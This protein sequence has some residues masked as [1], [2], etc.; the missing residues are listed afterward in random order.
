MSE[1]KLLTTLDSETILL[2][3]VLEK[4]RILPPNFFD[5]IITSPPYW[6][7]RDYGVEGQWGLEPDFHD[8]LKKLQILMTELKRVLKDSGTCWVNLGD[9]YSGGQSHSDWSHVD[10]RFISQAM[11][12][13]KFKGPRKNQIQAKSRM[14]IPSRF[15]I[16]C[17]DDGW[18]ARNEIPWIKP[19]AMP[20]SVKDRFTNKWEP[21]FFFAKSQK[22]YFN[23][24]AVREPCKTISKPFNVRVRDSDKLRFM[25]KATSNEE[26]LKQ[27]G[28]IDPRTG[29][30]K[31]NY[32]G[33]N[34]RYRNRKQANIPGQ[35]PNGISL[36]DNKQGS[37]NPKGKNPGDIF[38]IT[39]KPF[40]GSHFATFPPDL[41][42]KILK[43]ACP[44]NGFVLDPFF[45]AGTVGVVADEMNINWVGIELKKEYAN[46]AINRIG[47]G[48]LG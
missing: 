14:G 41:P 33:F 46:M 25:E 20:H 16:Q 39:V 6:G 31:A 21:V 12:D 1:Q 11:K 34:D 27:D 19:N 13:G 7:L 38:T 4:V 26:K 35:K 29:R 42:E 40:K 43:C 17:I 23:L 36:S 45:G 18:I 22:Y 30:P 37:T 47:K 2:G 10:D 15:Y 48:K 3:D 44:E 24:D 28:V 5:C 32:V 9:T 8:Y